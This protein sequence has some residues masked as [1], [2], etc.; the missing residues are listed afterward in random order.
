[1]IDSFVLLL[2]IY[3]N[4]HN[5]VLFLN[6]NRSFL[7]Q[8][9]V[10]IPCEFHHLSDL[11][12][13]ISIFLRNF[14]NIVGSLVEEASIGVK[15]TDEEAGSE[16]QVMV[17]VSLELLGSLLSLQVHVSYT[18]Q[19]LLVEFLLF[20]HLVGSILVCSSC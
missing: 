1:M 3:E 5:L 13:A 16:V 7:T 18:S 12:E 4:C 2:Q 8:V 11:F 10:V 9:I 20:K 15:Y 19:H 14:F 17:E 6:E